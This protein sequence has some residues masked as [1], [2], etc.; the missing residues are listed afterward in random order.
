MLIEDNVSTLR[1]SVEGFIEARRDLSRLVHERAAAAA[2][3][4][5]LESS[6]WNAEAESMPS[7]RKAAEAR[8]AECNRLVDS[9]YAF[10]CAVYENLNS[11]AS[12][13][14]EPPK[15]P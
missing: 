4:R 15:K 11:A 7:E 12:A 1:S 14:V 9:Q 13:M 2:R 10:V 5:E 8:L 3:W 6:Q